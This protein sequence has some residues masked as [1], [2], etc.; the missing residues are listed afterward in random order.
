MDWTRYLRNHWQV[1]TYGFVYANSFKEKVIEKVVEYWEDKKVIDEGDQVKSFLL[2]L[3]SSLYFTGIAY[4]YRNTH[5]PD[6]IVTYHAMNPY[7]LVAV[8]G[9]PDKAPHYQYRMGQE[10][11]GHSSVTIISPEAIDKIVLGVVGPALT[12]KMAKEQNI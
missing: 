5:A 9:T 8:A 12:E 2:S 6:G 4:V 7:M 11:L 3:C 10:V 1:G